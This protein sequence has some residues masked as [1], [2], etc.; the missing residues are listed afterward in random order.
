M[1]NV[2]HGISL[3]RELHRFP[4]LLQ[5]LRRKIDCQFSTVNHQFVRFLL[6]P[7]RM[8]DTHNY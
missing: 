1:K 8:L 4:N 5:S 3:P 6:Y 2:P 7:N